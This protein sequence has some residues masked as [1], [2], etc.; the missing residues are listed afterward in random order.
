MLISPLPIQ[1]I[2]NWGKTMI[3]TKFFCL[4]TCVEYCVLNEEANGFLNV[5]P[6]IRLTSTQLQDRLS[7]G[8]LSPLGRRFSRTTCSLWLSFYQEKGTTTENQI[9]PNSQSTEK[10]GHKR[11]VMG[12]K[13]WEPW[14]CYLACLPP[15]S[16]CRLLWVNQGTMASFPMAGNFSTAYLLYV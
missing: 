2:A 3:E 4:E 10:S 7:L 12:P 13:T 14:L 8:R 11:V 9:L 6:I 16:L 1:N 15:N 5:H